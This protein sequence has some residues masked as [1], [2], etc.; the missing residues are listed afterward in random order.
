MSKPGITKVL[1]LFC[2]CFAVS[3]CYAWT[4]PPFIYIDD[5]LKFTPLRSYQNWKEEI[6]A[7][8]ISGGPIVAWEWDWPPQ[9][10][11]IEQSDWPDRSSGR[12]RFNATGKYYVYATGYDE[13]DQW[14][15]DWALVYVFEMDLDISGVSDA[16]EMNP[17]KFL[18]RNKDDD[19]NDGVIDYDDGYNKDG[20]PGNAD[21][22]NPDEDDLVQISLSYE[23]STLPGYAKLESPYGGQNHIRVWTS[24]TKGIGNM[25]IGGSDEKEVWPIGRMPPTLWVEGYSTGPAELWLLFTPDQQVYPGGTYNHD[26]VKFTIPL[27]KL[28]KVGYTYIEPANTYSENTSIKITAVNASGQTYESFTGAV[29]IAEDT[30]DPDYV[31]IYSQN[32]GYLPSSVTLDPPNMGSKIF[33]AKSLAGPKNYCTKPSDARII[34]PNYDLYQANYLS[35]PQWTNDLGTLHA[36][37]LGNVYDWFETRTKDIFEGASGGLATVLSKISYYEQST[38][39][40]YGGWMDMDHTATSKVYF[41]PHYLATR[42]D[43]DAVDYCGDP[44]SHYHTNSVIHEAR[45]CYQDYL[46]TVDLGQP[47]DI[48]GKPNNDDDQDW[49]AETVPIAPTDYIL[50]TPASRNK[51]SSTDSFSGDATYDNYASGGTRSASDNVIE[52]D[53][54]TYAN[55]ND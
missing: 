32:G 38:D 7:D 4:E 2:L 14:D 34:T 15:S 29:N 31:E 45:H 12:A 23:P 36:K 37:A 16:S 25:I 26:P 51:C 11:D 41:N 49:L 44:R 28:E 43:S 5:W 53:A 13:Y 27:M 48:A 9:A 20:I 50:D 8:L 3:E 1:F 39:Y 21:D 47:D 19:D 35:V 33:I 55:D 18:C 30:S 22:A 24:P 54:A 6:W 46:T 52:K 40:D 17:G 42:L 10:Y